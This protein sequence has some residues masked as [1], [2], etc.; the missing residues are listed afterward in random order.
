MHG[1]LELEAPSANVEIARDCIIMCL[2]CSCAIGVPVADMGIGGLLAEVRL[3]VWHSE[4][5][6]PSE[7]ERSQA[8]A[9]EAISNIERDRKA[10]SELRMRIGDAS[11]FPGHFQRDLHRAVTSSAGKGNRPRSW[12]FPEHGRGRCQGRAFR[13]RRSQEQ[14]QEREQRPWAHNRLPVPRSTSR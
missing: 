1:G 6:K 4:W 11:V 13:Q 10:A 14:T 2:Q 9:Q 8:G 3:V 5:L 7:H 12:R